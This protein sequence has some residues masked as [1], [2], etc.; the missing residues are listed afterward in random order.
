MKKRYLFP[1]TWIVLFIGGMICCVLDGIELTFTDNYT[2]SVVIA[3]VC[4]LIGVLWD[5]CVDINRRDRMSRELIDWENVDTV[6]DLID[7][8]SLYPK[9]DKVI[10]IENGGDT[11][12]INKIRETKG[13]F[14]S[15]PTNIV[16]IDLT[17]IYEDDYWD[18]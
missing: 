9:D 15:C 14:S 7:M 10:F 2:F 5:G 8:L 3:V 18:D 1:I 11:S 4:F 13:G 16:E 12:K 17:E 6:Q